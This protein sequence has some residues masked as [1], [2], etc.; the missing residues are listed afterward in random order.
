MIPKVI[1]QTW[2]K[3]ELPNNILK[4]KEKMLSLNKDY[5]YFLFDDYDIE[6]FIKENYNSDTLKAFNMLNVG[7]AKADLWRYLILY[8]NGGIYL[9]IDSEIYSNLDNL[10][11]IND[12]AIISR[13]GN[14]GLFVQWC[15]IFSAKHPILKI[16]IDK[17]LDNILN[18]K[19]NDIL[20]LTGPYVY[21]ES[22]FEYVK[23]INE[24]IYEKSDFLI[25]KLFNEND[26][27]I[28]VYDYDYKGFCVFKNMYHSEI[29]LSSIND[30]KL[31]HWTQ[32]KKIFK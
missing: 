15:L 4:I 31:R 26:L 3:K 27:N 11:S 6:L 32:Q 5:K 12:N 21:S 19:T 16:C 22:I 30:N 1:Y 17:C 23:I 2:Y 10:I 24:N 14:Y 9:D 18:Q 28:R 13:E 25:N 20:K 29:E 7:A 8:K